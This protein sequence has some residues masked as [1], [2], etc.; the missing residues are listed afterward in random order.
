MTGYVDLRGPVFHEG[1][2]AP[3]LSRRGN[4]IRSVPEPEHEAGVAERL[5]APL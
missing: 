2:P 3:A 1:P 5:L 4:E